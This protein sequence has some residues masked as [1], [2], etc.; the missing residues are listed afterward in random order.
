MAG[1]LDEFERLEDTDKGRCVSIR[2]LPVSRTGVGT[3]KTQAFT[4]FLFRCRLLN[5]E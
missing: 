3:G 1:L 5:A 4:I 2:K